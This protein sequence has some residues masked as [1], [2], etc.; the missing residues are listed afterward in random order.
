MTDATHTKSRLISVI[1]PSYNSQET[2]SETLDSLLSQTHECWEAIIIDGAS[3]DDT[4]SIIQTYTLRDSRFSLIQLEE[5]MGVSAARNKGLE[6]SAGTY[7]NFLD[8][9]DYLYPD[10]FS[11]MLKHME[12]QNDCSGVYG[13]HQLLFVDG[14]KKQVQ[15]EKEADITF[16]SLCLGNKFYSNFAILFKKTSLADAGHFDEEII[17]GED[18]D[19]WIRLYRA[20]HW[21]VHMNENTGC[22]RVRPDSLSR[23][24][25]AA[26]K[27]HSDVIDKI[28]SRDRRCPRPLGKY[29]EGPDSSNKSKVYKNL[30]NYHLSGCI[31]SNDAESIKR[32]LSMGHRMEMPKLNAHDLAHGVISRISQ[33][34]EGMALLDSQWPAFSKVIYNTVSCIASACSDRLFI[35]DF[36]LAMLSISPKSANHRKMLISAL[37]HGAYLQPRKVMKLFI[38]SFC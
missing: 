8:S 30:N 17:A 2:I 5:N 19:L 20:G 33:H 27:G 10:T 16:D 32:I 21:F 18:W 14:S 7:L 36:F 9:D 15:A 38:R 11:L 22:Y 26:W 1:I 29:I 23:D 13:N 25:F 4:A 6:L 12:Q 28:F 31:A 3:S 34:P 35:R 37:R 24:H